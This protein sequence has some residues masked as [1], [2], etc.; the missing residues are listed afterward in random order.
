MT[1]RRLAGEVEAVG[2][3]DRDKCAILPATAGP[4]D[5]ISDRK[6]FAAVSFVDL[7][8]PQRTSAVSAQLRNG[9]SCSPRE[10]L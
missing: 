4:G 6:N 3:A 10:R 9:A 1:D 5:E 8:L 7:R 2:V